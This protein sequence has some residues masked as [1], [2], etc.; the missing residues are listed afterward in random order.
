MKL[1]YVPLREQFDNS[2][3]HA[4]EYYL[5]D[6][7]LSRF[8]ESL[9]LKEDAQTFAKRSLGYKHYYCKEFGTLRPILPDGSFYTPFDPLQGLNFEPAPGFHEGNAWNYTFYVPHDIGGLKRLMGGEK[10]FAAKLRKVFDENFYDPAN[11]PDITY[12]YLF[13]Q[14]KGEEWRTDLLVNSLLKKY[15]KNQPDGIPGNDDTGTMSAWAV[16]SMMG[17]YPDCPGIP[18]YTLVA[19]AFDKIILH[20]D[21]RYYTQ[22]TLV[23]ECERPSPKAIYT[24][25]ITVNG[26]N[27][28]DDSFSTKI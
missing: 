11:E 27:I 25:R 7:A 13:A 20:L 9:G 18:R 23:I 16:F 6:F 15:F 1:G 22:D 8:A 2:V 24:D 12:P 14:V 21:P 26:K 5:A 28:K 10:K 3:S 4:L 17:L 19:P